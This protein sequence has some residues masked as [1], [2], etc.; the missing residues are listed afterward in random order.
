MILM[1]DNYDSFTY[2]LVQYLQEMGQEVLVEKNDR[3]SINQIRQ[4]NPE[5][6]IISPGPSTPMEAG[7]SI[8]VVKKLGEDFPIL[9]V[10]LGHQSIACAFGAQIEINYRLMHGKISPVLHDGSALFKNIP[11][12]FN[13]TRYHSLVVRAQSLP[14]ELQVSAWTAEGEVM[15]IRHLKYPLY[16]VQFHPESIFTGEGKKL[17]YNF[18]VTV[19]PENDSDYKK[20]AV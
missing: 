7:I 16:G 20:A 13:A 1:I 6:I 19:Q 18:L 11:S 10:C 15:G 9:G 3:L 17:L 5:S 12:P 2:N 4:L 8:E 14:P